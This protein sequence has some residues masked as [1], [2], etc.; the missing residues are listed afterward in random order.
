[1]F[2]RLIDNPTSPPQWMPAVFAGS[3]PWILTWKVLS[4]AP[5]LAGTVKP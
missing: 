2:D 1:M 4:T 3:K 5:G